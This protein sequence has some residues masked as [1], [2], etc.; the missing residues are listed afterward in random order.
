[1]STKVIH[2]ANCKKFGYSICG[3]NVLFGDEFLN[4]DV[5]FEKSKVTC[6]ECLRIIG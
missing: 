4:S 2:L 5:V 6:E 3:K 1:M